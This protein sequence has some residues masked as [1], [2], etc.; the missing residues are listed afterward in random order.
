[1]I[2]SDV[3]SLE[4]TD[5][6]DVHDVVI[7]GDPISLSLGALDDEGLTKTVTNGD[8]SWFVCDLADGSCED[9]DKQSGSASTF[10]LSAGASESERDVRVEAVYHG[11]GA[12]R[13][14]FS[15][16]VTSL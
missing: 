4:I 13:E 3:A 8:V 2:T 6:V 15:F 11:L 12:N 16:V 14:D 9:A 5:E 1:L 10:G 7:G